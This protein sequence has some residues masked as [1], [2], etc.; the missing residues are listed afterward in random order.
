MKGTLTPM[1]G[2]IEEGGAVGAEVEDVKNII[3]SM[4]R[5]L[6][7]AVRGLVPA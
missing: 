4:I 6:P 2:T 3:H 1:K 5:T 7:L